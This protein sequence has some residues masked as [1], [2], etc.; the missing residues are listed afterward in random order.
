MRRL[1]H[2]DPIKLDTVRDA[3]EKCGRYSAAYLS[4][5]TG[6]PRGTVRNYLD[7]LNLPQADSPRGPQNTPRK[8]HVETTERKQPDQIRIIDKTPIKVSGRQKCVV[9]LY[10][11]HLPHNGASMLAPS[12]H[13]AIKWCHAN[14]PDEIIIGG[15]YLDLACI[16]HWNKDFPGRVQNK[17][18]HRDFKVGNMVLDIIQNI[19]KNVTYLKGN[20]EEWLDREIERDPSGKTGLYDLRDALRLYD[21]GI[22]LI[23]E[24][25]IY[26][27]GEANF[28][29]GWY[30]GVYHAR[31]TGDDAGGNVFYGHAHDVQSFSKVRRLGSE[32]IIAQSCGCLCDMNPHYMRNKPNKWVN[33][34]LIV[35]FNDD[36]TFTY[37]LPIIINGRFTGPDGKLYG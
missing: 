21:R 1:T 23:P 19:Q 16:S 22:D 25:G 13:A 11:L 3:V 26:E 6:L 27:I 15:D 37:Y 24:N 7:Y 36:G 4:K 34:F 12:A 8:P 30:C 32:P 18:L 2:P 5:V 29:H 20:H 31:K 10:D 33:A 9:V 17:H 14:K 35:Y 28:I